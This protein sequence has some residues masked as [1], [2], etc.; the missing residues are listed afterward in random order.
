MSE[1]TE[2]AHPC[3]VSA[4]AARTVFKWADGIRRLQAVYAHPIE[5]AATPPRTVARGQGAQ[6]RCLPAIPPGSRYFGAKLM[7]GA[8][9]APKPGMEY[10]I[11]MFDRQTSRI[12]AILDGNLVTAYRTAATSAA[13]LD[14]LARPGAARLGVLGSGLEAS[15]H[16]RAFAAVRALDR[17]NIFSPTPARREALANELSAELGVPCTAVASAEAAAADASIVLA[18]ARSRG[19][20]PILFGD[21]LAHGATVVSIGSTVPEQR[22][23]DV[24]VVRRCDLIVCDTLE[25][26]LHETGDMLA[27]AQTGV[28]FR[29]KSYSL[30]ALM[31]GEI[32]DQ[33]TAAQM[34]M[35]KSVGGGV[36]DLVVAELILLEAIEAGLHTPL[37]IEFLTKS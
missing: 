29:D 4:E 28:S 5:P 23:I 6:L 32:E 10:V 36:Q 37:P 18:A 14:R 30:N 26:V 25:E 1:R 3:F 15:M 35:F 21:W 22:E 27:A 19:E 2:R 9:R 24:S 8:F 16:V 17:V 7:G 11:V 12:G 34:P 33:R 13:A 31:R 20:V